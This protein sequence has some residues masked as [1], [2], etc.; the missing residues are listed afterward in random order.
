MIAEKCHQIQQL[1]PP[2]SLHSNRSHLDGTSTVQENPVISFDTHMEVDNG[3]PQE[4]ITRPKMKELPSFRFDED[5]DEDMMRLVGKKTTTHIHTFVY[6][7]FF[8]MRHL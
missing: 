7:T 3:Y 5:E 8:S 1:A 6:E 2:P 4:E